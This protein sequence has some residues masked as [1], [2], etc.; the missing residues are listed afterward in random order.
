M[1]IVAWRGRIRVIA[2]VA[3]LAAARVPGL[4]AQAAGP[5]TPPPSVVAVGPREARSRQ[6]VRDALREVLERYP[7]S[8]GQVLK[9]DASLLANDAYLQPY[10]ELRVFLQQYPEV[11]RAP[12]YYLNFV[13][14]PENQTPPSEASMQW[15]VIRNVLEM[16]SVGFVMSGLAFVLLWLVTHFLAHRRWLR[17]TRLQMDIH[18]R[19]MERLQTGEDVKNYLESTATGRLLSDTPGM[20]AGRAW[21]PI[22]R[23]LLAV[24]VGVVLSC[25]G[26]GIL[27]ARTFIGATAAA[28]DTMVF[29]GVIGLA[30]G[31]GFALAAV[32][33]FVLS[34]RFGLVHAAGAGPRDAGQA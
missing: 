20:D 13:W 9:L 4:D 28:G 30:L 22:S 16:I 31:I 17:S 1:A 3:L 10:P 18:N 2:V 15:N 24:Q 8:L 27:T 29:F 11:P 14:M 25:A 34:R 33:S 32:A 19:L 5:A 7:P 21:T 26:L 6:E 12:D 23:I